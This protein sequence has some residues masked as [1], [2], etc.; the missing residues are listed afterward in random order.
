VI[1]FRLGRFCPTGVTGCN[2]QTSPP[3]RDAG[4][5]FTTVSGVLPMSRRPLNTSGG[6]N[7]TTFDKSLLGGQEYLGRVFYSTF[8]GDALF[9]A[10]P[11]LDV[12]QTR[13]I[14]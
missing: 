4:I 14:R 9:M 3:A 7:V 1:G 11:G 10:P 6:T 12:G 8:V 13:T 2:P 5:S